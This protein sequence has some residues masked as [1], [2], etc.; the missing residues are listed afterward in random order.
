MSITGWHVLSL[1]VVDTDVYECD[2]SNNTGTSLCE[3]HVFLLLSNKHVERIHVLF[4]H[5]MSG[6]CGCKS[7][8]Y[9]MNSNIKW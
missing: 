6:A 3:L 2:H 9:K 4:H 1:L 8:G 5:L 7:V